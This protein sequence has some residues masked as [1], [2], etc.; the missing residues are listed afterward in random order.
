MIYL[1][2]AATTRVRP[3]VLE[4]MIPFF[5]GEYGNPSSTYALGRQAHAAITEAREKV[6]KAIGA[7]FPRE[8]FFTSCGTE[9][10]N[11]AIKGAAYA[12]AEKGR[13]I[14]TTKVEHHAV[15]ET[16]EFLEKQGFEVTYVDPDQYGMVSLE[17]VQAAVRPDTILISVMA[18][19]NEV[20]T[21]NPIAEIGAFAREHKILFHTDAVQAVGHMPIDVQAMN[22]DLLSLSGHKFHAPK[23]VGALYIRAGLGVHVEKFM[24]GGAQERSRRAGTENVASIVGMGEAIELITEEMEQEIPRITKL[25]DAMIHEILETIPYTHLNGHPTKRLAGNVNISLEFVEAE[26]TLLSLDLAGIAC[27]SGSA[28]NS[29]SLSSSHVLAAMGVSPDVA[30]S[31]LRFTLA[32]YNTMEDVERTVCELRAIMERLRAI[33]PLFHARNENKLV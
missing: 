1:D 29:A 15:L 16:C 8:V 3:E 21:I 6:A 25:R 20:G 18:A 5:E 2:N 24:H 26:A 30:K 4:K 27:S 22:V 14:V 31:S 7:A 28:C 13:H 9:S 32:R 33:S 19:N 12:N 10:D 11:W 17:A 23:G